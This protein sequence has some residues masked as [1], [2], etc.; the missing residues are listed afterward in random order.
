MDII[1]FTLKDKNWIFAKTVG[2]WYN[3][4][5][6]GG[7]DYEKGNYLHNHWYTVADICD[8]SFNK[9]FAWLYCGTYFFGF[10]FSRFADTD[11]NRRIDYRADRKVC[12][13]K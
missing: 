8:S 4:P 3:L 10:R 11:S 13:Q 9:I 2:K 5:C 12:Q 7:E 6:R 1:L